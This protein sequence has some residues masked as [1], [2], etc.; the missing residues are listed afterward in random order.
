[1]RINEM[2]DTGGEN[3][4]LAAARPRQD[5]ERYVRRVLD[6]CHELA[7]GVSVWLSLQST[8]SKNGLTSELDFVE[9]IE[10]SN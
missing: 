6:G 9:L 8:F 5:L 10:V 4:R 3:F 2:D 1:M 7:R